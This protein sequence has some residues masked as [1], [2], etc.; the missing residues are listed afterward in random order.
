MI[1]RPFEHKRQVSSSLVLEYCHKLL[2]G[3]SA[4]FQSI[5]HP[6][7]SVVFQKSNL[8]KFLHFSLLPIALG[9][10]RSCSCLPLLI[11]APTPISRS[12]SQ[13]WW[14]RLIPMSTLWSVFLNFLRNSSH[15]TNIVFLL[16]PIFIPPNPSRLLKSSYIPFLLLWFYNTLDFHH[17]TYEPI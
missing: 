4:S 14:I 7:A 11:Q 16:I 9:A 2:L 15:F 10:L 17:C 12:L 8:N 5:L 13:P 3:L 1:P 6:T